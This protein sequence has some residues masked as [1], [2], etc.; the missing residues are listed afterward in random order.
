NR[1]Y[2]GG[3]GALGQ[4]VR[5]WG[6]NREVIGIVG[7]ERFKGLTVAA[8]PAIYLPLTQAPL[9]SAILVRTDGDPSRLASDV[10]RVVRE[11]DPLLPLF[12][13]EPLTETLGNSQAERRFIM[14]V[15]VSF[16]GVALLLAVIGVH[17]VL[18]YAVS[19]RTRE[20]GIRVAL[21]AD[22]T[23]IR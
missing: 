19:Q 6:S 4:L 5:L 12:G 7:N 21:G 8:P 10:R 13:V 17:G 15:L 23:R 2:F 22:M 3:S 16:A 9:A 11:L 18:S 1:R 20:I 14:I